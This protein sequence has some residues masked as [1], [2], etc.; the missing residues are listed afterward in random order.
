MALSVAGEAEETWSLLRDAIVFH[1]HHGDG[2]CPVC[3][4]PAALT[5][6]WRQAAE[7]RLKE[8]EWTASEASKIKGEVAQLKARARGFLASAPKSLEQASVDGIDAS[9]ALAAW[10][11]W[12]I[13]VDSLTLDQLADHVESY[14]LDLVEAVPALQK[15]ASEVLERR[16]DEW[17]PIA[18]ALTAWLQDAR[19]AVRLGEKVKALK[20][21]ESWLKEAFD[22]VRAARFEPIANASIAI[23]NQLR[24]QSN[25][26]LR[27]VILAGSKTQ[28]RVELDVTVDD[29]EGAAL[30]VMSQGELHSLALSLFFPRV[31]L[32][33]SPFRFLVI[34][35]PVQSMD[36]AREMGSRGSSRSKRRRDRSSCSRM[37]IGWR[38]RSDNSAS[39]RRSSK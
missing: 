23:W 3:G 17:R 13:D 15:Q 34:D 39:K 32:P 2:V 36:P 26:E 24:M 31:T 7:E 19:E 8:L 16:E 10:D 29:V 21:A 6:P 37:T 1:E 33:D 30:G 11:V 22:E 9:D 38:S 14:I 12:S 4:V 28:R 5:K 20:G 27:R 35:D 18:V 25:V